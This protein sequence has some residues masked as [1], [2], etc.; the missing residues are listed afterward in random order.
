M[1]F[2]PNARTGIPVFAL[3]ATSWYPIVTMKMR[4]SPRPSVQ[5]ATPRPESS[6]GAAAARLPSSIRYIHS[7]SPVAASIATA[8]RLVAAVA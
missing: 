7:S 4:S 6:R 2:C 3:S 5:Y 8:S 1:P